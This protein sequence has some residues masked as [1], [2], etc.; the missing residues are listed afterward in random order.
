[1]N[2]LNNYALTEIVGKNIYSTAALNF[3][4]SYKQSIK[5]Y[6]YKSISESKARLLY[7]LLPKHGTVFIYSLS[8]KIDR[9]INC[10][11]YMFL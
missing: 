7:P 2:S 9:C 1:M 11:A 8:S 3:R 10:C 6:V 5:N 4:G